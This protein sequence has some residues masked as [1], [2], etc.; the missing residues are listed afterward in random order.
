M[1]HLDLISSVTRG[2]SARL[3]N[4]PAILALGLALAACDA[5][6]GL[7]SLD[8]VPKEKIAAVIT[9]DFDNGLEIVEMK[10]TNGQEREMFGVKVYVIEFEGTARATKSMQKGG[11]SGS[12]QA[13]PDM[14]HRMMSCTNCPGPEQVEAGKSYPI[15]GEAAFQMKEKGWDAHGLKI[16]LQNP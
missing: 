13:Q 2:W 8:D 5:S 4:R 6:G 14:A 1:E 9:E 7:P 11:M 15:Q 12:Y 3:R 16:D 10:K